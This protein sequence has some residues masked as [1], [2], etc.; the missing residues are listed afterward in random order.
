MRNSF[1]RKILGVIHNGC[2]SPGD[3]KVRRQALRDP[4]VRVHGTKAVV[5][6]K[7]V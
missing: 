5:Q 2:N 3:N 6:R 4:C 1:I 7:H